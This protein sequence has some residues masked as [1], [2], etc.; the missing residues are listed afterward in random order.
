ML[1]EIYNTNKSWVM[2]Q[3]S[4]WAYDGPGFLPTGEPLFETGAGAGGGRKPGQV[5]RPLGSA[6]VARAR[7]FSQRREQPQAVG[8]GAGEGLLADVAGIGEHGTQLRPDPG[9]S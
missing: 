4:G 3:I 1:G 2:G 7:V 8:V 9:C 5:Q 6:G